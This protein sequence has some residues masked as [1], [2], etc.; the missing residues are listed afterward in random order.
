MK[1]VIG[2]DP[3]VHGGIVLLNGEDGEVISILP[4][5]KTE[6]ELKEHL[7]S[8]KVLQDIFGPGPA[9]IE[10]VGYM[11]GDGGKGAFTFG[12]I[13]GELRMGVKMLGIEVRDVYPAVWQSHLS[14][15]SGGDKN[16]T[17]RKAQ[18]LF[19]QVRKITHA[20][21]DALLIAEY[22][23]RMEEGRQNGAK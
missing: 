9:Y 12:K 3:G 8:I 15:L 20:V 11:R 19:P 14:C 18:E 10:K 13:Y 1:T 16:V 6:D 4:I 2:I 5:P 23:R 21:A 17:K 22:G 7:H